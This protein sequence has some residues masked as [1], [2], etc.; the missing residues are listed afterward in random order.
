MTNGQPNALLK[1][2]R[3]IVA[4]QTFRNVSDRE[5]L[6]AFAL[7]QDEAAFAVLVERHGSMILGV[8]RR[9]LR[10]VHDAEDA[11]QATFLV[12]A[13]KAGSIRKKDSLGSWLHGV[14]FRVA[15]DLKKR[16]ARRQSSSAA[17]DDVTGRDTVT[18]VT[19]REAQAAL[20]EE[21][22]LLPENYRAPLIL[23]YLEGKT[24]DEAAHQLGWKPG[25][26]KSRLERGREL[27]RK[28]L[29]SRGI[30]PS[31]V[32]L[33]A[34]FAETASATMPAVLAFATVKAASLIAVGKATSGTLIP[35]DVVSLSEGV[36]KTMFT[37]KLK[38]ATAALVLVAALAVGAGGL[39]YQTQAAEPQQ[40]PPGKAE[41]ARPQP[42]ALP[43]EG[44]EG[45]VRA[46]AFARDGKT[47]A[48]GG[49]DGTVRIWDAAT[50][51][52]LRKLERPLARPSG[53]GGPIGGSE[54]GGKNL[55][56]GEA[57]RLA[58]AP[59]GRTIVTAY[60]GGFAGAQISR[61]VDTGNVVKR[62][63]WL[64][65]VNA[66]AFE[67]DGKWNRLVIGIGRGRNSVLAIDVPA[68]QILFDFKSGSAPVAVA[69]SPDSKF[70]ACADQRG[71]VHL[72]DVAKVAA[73][74]PVGR[75]VGPGEEGPPIGDAMLTWPKRGDVKTLAFF[76]DGTKVAVLD[77]GKDVRI[78]HVA[79]GKEDT[80]F[81]GD[82][83]VQA[84]AL[85]PDGK[86]AAT[87][88]KRV[89][90]LWDVATG[91]EQRRFTAEGVIT[92]LVFAP[93]GQRLAT[94]GAGGA[95]VWHL[96]RDQK[97]IPP[98][99]K[100]TEKE[101]ASL[102]ADL[103]S[104]DGSKVYEAARLLRADPARSVPY[105]RERLS[106]SAPRLDAPKVK[107]LIADL[108]ADEFK[109]R[110]RATKALEKLGKSAESALRRGLAGTPS[111]EARRRL[112]GLLKNVSGEV[113]LTPEQQ[114]DVRAVRLLAQVGTPEA[115]QALEA[116]AQDAPGWWVVQEATASLDPLAKQP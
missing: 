94:A 3:K 53:D 38:I 58:F 7:R 104:N 81:L 111:V 21:L 71:A 24:R 87:V 41:P 34:V 40:P 2:I 65:E 67:P 27:L 115:R 59:D 22:Y 17:V 116:L 77:G 15:S 86:R 39:L 9:V 51:Q 78:L 64:D 10:S 72:L 14:A 98:D 99:L 35:I 90:R 57:V 36:L 23:C 82:E 11:C 74:G 13:R 48:T 73:G 100:L 16:L 95:F 20:D 1:H 12:L 26:L 31:V 45:A 109:T 80:A 88:G 79:T 83:A 56:P 96:D 105:L 76:P 61:D 97:P 110:E 52:T 60:G 30:A 85:S 91:K 75:T 55:P 70:V 28:R 33:S 44:H 5:L 6:D 92:A 93:D 37:S 69:S 112:E 113:T 32:L 106:S 102:W 68:G 62:F 8:C 49:A 89:V 25:I 18:E 108:D 63:D 54:R 43:L 4:A 42:A 114:R 47:L 101:L 19:L 103:A 84:V 66:F 107:Q 29:V 50:G 46:V